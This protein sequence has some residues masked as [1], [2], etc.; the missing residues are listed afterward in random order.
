MQRLLSFLLF[1][2]LVLPAAAQDGAG[3]IHVTAKTQQFGLRAQI[4]DALGLRIMSVAATDGSELVASFGGAILLQVRDLGAGSLYTGASGQ[5]FALGTDDFRD[6]SAGLLI[7]W[8]TKLG[9]RIDGF[10]EVG[11]DYLFEDA[12]VTTARSTGVGL[13]YRL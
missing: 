11:V 8:R 13:S 10:A 12:F 2:L 5:V 7:G 9:P 1:T 4:T 6:A 3:A